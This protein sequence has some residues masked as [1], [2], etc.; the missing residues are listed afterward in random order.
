MEGMRSR[1]L[2]CVPVM[3]LLAAASSSP[4]APLQ[5]SDAAFWKQWGDGQAELSGYDLSFR[6]TGSRA[7]ASR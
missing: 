2:F 4:V 7:T 6:A 5:V 3:L 1:I